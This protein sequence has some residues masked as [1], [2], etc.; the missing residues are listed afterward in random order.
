MTPAEWSVV[1]EILGGALER[2]PGERDAYLEEACSGDPGLRQRVER[3]IAA[4]GQTWELMEG[5]AVE[6]PPSAAEF[7]LPGRGDRIGSYEVQHEIGRGGMGVV[8]LARRA[9]EQF[10]KRVAIKLARIGVADDWIERR[11]RSERQIVASL[12][13]P[14]IARLL[15]GGATADGRAYLVMEY[16]EG[17]PLGR[18][19]DTRALGTRQ[20]LEVFLDVCAAVAYAHQHLVVHRDLKPANILVTPEGSVKLLD[21]GIAKLIDPEPTGE[22][23]ERT[24]TLFR[25]LTPDYASPEQI[26]GEPISTASDIYALG[27]VLYELLTGSKPYRT[28]DAPPEELFRTICEVEPPK[29]STVTKPPLSKELAGDLDTILQTALRKEPQ[30][31]YASVEALAADVRRHLTGLPVE[32]R[33]DTFAY[34]A[35]KFVRRHRVVVSA[36]LLVVAALA[37][38]L[39]MTLR[40]ARRARAAE[41]RAEKR[42]NDVR[43]LAN[44]FLF[45]FHDAIR[46]LPGSTP[47]RALVVRRGLEYLDMLSRES[48]GNPELRRELAE[49]YQKVGDV[50]GN[51]YHPNLGDLKGALASYDKAIG[52]LEPVV[53]GAPTTASD[54]EKSTLASAY[55]VGGGIRV[56]AGEPATAVTMAE[57]GL[58]LRR[59]LAEKNPGDGRRAAELAQ[60]WQFYAF[61]LSAAGRASES[62]EA[63]L[64]QAAILRERLAATPTDRPLLRSLDQNLYL[65]AGALQS[66]GDFEEARRTYEE[67][68]L[69]GERLLLED[70]GSSQFRRDLGWIRMDLGSLHRDR[71]DPWKAIAQYQLALSLFEWILAADPKNTDGRVGV[72]MTHQYL[73]LVR[74]ETEGPSAALEEFEKA[75][76][77]YQPVR[78]ADPS[79]AFIERRLADLYVAF[80][81]AEEAAAKGAPSEGRVGLDRACRYYALAAEKF[82][83][84]KAAGRLDRARAE[85]SARVAQALARCGGK[86]A[87]AAARP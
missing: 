49:A 19:C 80:A 75:A 46:D 65:R 39:V 48:A 40:E 51:P 77:A 12:D 70:P 17:E 71:H 62:Y 16:V 8:Y 63:L 59:G 26:R 55:L 83:S 25:L 6:A 87:V 37:G 61:N 52:L 72:G 32:A 69:V 85:A 9:D 81:E 2:V 78:S 22:S 66:R 43:T 11:F 7:R 54:A 14:N 84:M 68:A 3:L 34:R 4:D 24:G 64:K 1:K 41:A 67:A 56:V 18:W 13:H 29:A 33:T 53:R 42:F 47:A 5:A 10:E 15:D 35:G 58:A 30:R 27:I 36:A 38:G 21:F 79:N 86:P 57:K 76:A 28:A 50:E 31:R 73:G 20:R 82:G 45:E 60:A 74:R 44:S 23:A